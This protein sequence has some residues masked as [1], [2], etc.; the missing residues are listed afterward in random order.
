MRI[1]YFTDAYRPQTNG[2]VTSVDTFRAALEKMG[3]EV[4][5]FAP[6]LKGALPQPRTMRFY[7][8]TYFGQP[9][10]KFVLPWGQGCQV[11]DIAKLNLDLIH[12]Q[13]E[14]GLGL[15]GMYL[16]RKHNI[17]AIFTNHTYWNTYLHY[18]PGPAWMYRSVARK[19]HS[20]LNERFP[21]VISPTRLMRDT[22]RGY[23]VRTR[24]EILPTGV[25]LKTC[26]PQKP[27]AAVRQALG[28]P[29]GA[30]LFA[31]AGRLGQ[32]K[33]WDLAFGALQLFKQRFP[34]KPFRFALMGGGPE[35]AN[36]KALA[37][38]LGLEK[39]VLF[40][41]YVPR[42]QVVDTFAAADVFLF[43]SQS[44]T[45]G[46]VLI[47]ALAQGTPCVCVDVMG[48]GEILRDGKGGLLAEPN[49][50][51][52]ADQLIKLEEDPKLA[53]RLSREAKLKAKSF[54]VAALTR[55]L[56]GFYDET[57]ALQKSRA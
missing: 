51:D 13:T 35:E 29:K 21:I 26:R 5:V 3:H 14:F 7:G 50:R 17:P 20:A 12:V 9:E 10:Y 31:S 46:M 27:A 41:G 28:V 4:W 45:Q 25:D 8:I 40:T 2:V 33:S 48:P 36:L 55:R 1:G 56:V 11:S 39:E 15:L 54:D 24:I 19:W 53:L 43:A 49:A 57:I 37:C 22:L 47:E 30:R 52:L 34:R 38:K 32:E 18:L 23:G 42:P 6:A 44:E 16:S